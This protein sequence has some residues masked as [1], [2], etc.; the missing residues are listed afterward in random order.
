M[1]ARD[2]I[3]LQR[4]LGESAGS[5]RVDA[6]MHLLD[7]LP[8]LL[9]APD[10]I[11]NV[12]NDG[13]FIGV[14]DS[15]SMLEALGRQISSRGDCSVVE[16]ECAPADYSASHLARA[17]EDADVHLVDMFTTPIEHGLLRVTLRVRCEDPEAVVHHLERYGY[18]V[19][20]SFAHGESLLPAVALDR[21]LAVRKLIE[22]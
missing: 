11:L 20:D 3:A 13:E 16:V 10:R 8:R 1:K 7:V 4:G 6:G 18:T 5:E 15:D 12:D 19:S 21:L 2:A 17:V 9:D 14:I 22:L